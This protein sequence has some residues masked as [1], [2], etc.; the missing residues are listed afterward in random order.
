MNRRAAATGLLA[1]ALLLTPALATA[2][3]GGPG[4]GDPYFPHAGNTGYEVDHYDLRVHYAHGSGRIRARTGILATSTQDLSRFDLDLRGL[5]VRRVEVDGKRART[6]RAGQ[7]LVIKPR[8]PIANGARFRVTV[9]YD[10]KPGPVTDPDG[11]QEGWLRTP[12][13]A[14]VASEPQGSPSWFPCNDTPADKA[15]YRI[16]VTVP[17]GLK[18]MS[19]GR[20]VSDSRRGP[21]RTMVWR[22]RQ[23]MATYLVTAT[24]GRFRVTRGHADGVP[25]VTAVDPAIGSAPAIRAMPRIIRFFSHKFGPYPFDAL[26]AIVDQSS[27]GYALETQTR[28]L[29]SANPQSA[30]VAHEYAHQWFGDSVSL[31]RWREIWLNE[32]FAT[33]AQWLWQAHEGGMSLRRHFRQAYATPASDKPAW[34]PPPGDPGS[35][36]HLFAGSIYFRGAMTLEALREKIGSHDLFHILREWAAVH[37]YGNVT[38]RQFIQLAESVSGRNLHHFFGVWLYRPA[39]PRRGSW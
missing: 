28:P 8:S 2:D 30:T 14:F 13:G 25:T 6:R 33:F 11:S 29:Y 19:N 16:A 20:L 21:R 24:I 9:R 34:Q 12:D 27:A 4:A 15:T 38:T 17:R 22:E 3:A 31:T 23:P 36:K 18:A 5:H 1:A 26:G 7:E 32:G 10:G 39:K 35:P 37:Q